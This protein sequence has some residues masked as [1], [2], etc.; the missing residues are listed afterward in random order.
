MVHRGMHGSMLWQKYRRAPPRSLAETI[1]I[2]NAY[3]D[4]DPTM[5]MPAAGPNQI[6]PAYEAA[7][8]PQQFDRQDFKN[9]RK[10]ERRY[11]TN[12][13]GAVQNA[14]TVDSKFHAKRMASKKKH[15]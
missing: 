8:G 12:F 15:T 2:A 13:V 5:P 9:K 1:E 11:N 3:A 6:N 14:P 7:G 10:E 4:A